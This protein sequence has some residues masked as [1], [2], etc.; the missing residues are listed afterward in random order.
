MVDLSTTTVQTKV[1]AAGATHTPISRA[2]SH[3][4]MVLCGKTGAACRAMPMT[5]AATR[6]TGIANHSAGVPPGLM[7]PNPH[8]FFSGFLY[9][10]GLLSGMISR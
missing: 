9:M 1:M 6:P 3:A 5:A 4:F 7:R 2:L 10:P 8:G